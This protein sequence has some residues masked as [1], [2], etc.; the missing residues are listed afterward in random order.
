MTTPADRVVEALRASL[1]ENERLRHENHRL[2]ERAR[3]PIAI[4]AMSCRYPGGVGTPEELWELVAAGRDAIGEFPA[5]RGWDLD[6]LFDAD[7]DHPGTSYAREGGFLHDAP[8][9]DADFF[10]ISPREAIAMDPQQRLLLEAVWEAVERTGTDPLALRGS[11]T[12]VF[13]GSHGQ[14]YGALQA[15][16]ARGV[17]G[18]L[19]TGSGGA[20]LSGRVAYTL[21]LAGPAVT[22]DTACSSSLVALHLAC[23][24]LRDDD[25]DRALV[26]GVSVMSTPDGWIAF[27]RQRGLA[28]DGRCKAFAAAA[29][30]TG[31]AEGVGVLVL[32]RLS[33]ARRAGRPVLALVRGSAIN[34]DGASNG[35]T[36]PSGPA[37]ERVIRQALAAA[38]LTPADVDA[39]EAHGT[40]TTLGDPIEAHAVLAAYG[41]DRPAGRPLL[42]GSLKSNI[43]HAQAAAG[44]GGVI[45]MVQAMRH[46]E[47]PRTLHVDAPSPHV[48]WSAGAVE[49]LTEHRPWPETGRPR[50][51]GV[52]SFGISGTNAHAILEQA[53]A[54]PGATTVTTAAERPAYPLACPVSAKTPAALRAHAGRL[55]AHL[56]D[57][58]GLDPADVAHTLATARSAFRERAV[59]I[60]AD[61]AGLLAGLDAVATGEPAPGV[62][63][64]TAE[65]TRRPALL[66]SGQ[67]AQRAGMGRA[68]AA[69]FPEFAAVLARTCEPLDA[70]LAGGP[71]GT[72]AHRPL[73]AVL[74]AEPGSPD[75]GLLDRTVYTQAGLFALE[76]ALFRLVESWGVRPALVLGHSIGGLAAAHVAGVF[77]L[78][79]ACALVAAR[80]RLM[81]ALPE[82][83]AMLSV[84]AAEEEIAPLLAAHADDLSVAAVN[85]P[86][87]TVLSGTAAA[88]ERIAGVLAERGVRTRRLRVSHAFHSPL[89]E[90]MLAEF[91]AVAER[92]GYAEPRIP[93]VSDLTG[94]IADPAEITTAD[95]WVRHIRC[96]VRYSD[97]V[98]SA[99]ALGARTFLELGPDG[100]LSA[101]GRDCLPATATGAAPLF[102]PAL[103]RTRPEDH[104]LIEAMAALHTRGA[105]SL[106]PL[107]PGGGTRPVQLPTYPFQRQRYWPAGPAT[108]AD[109]PAPDAA[110]TAP[111]TATKDVPLARRLAAL[112]AGERDAALLRLVR[113]HAA[114]VLGHTHR[115]AVPAD[116][117]FQELGFDSLTAVEF[118]N[119]LDTATGLRLPATLV[120]DHP[121]PAALAETLRAE[122]LGGTAPAEAPATGPG[123]PAEPIAI[124]GMGCRL[125]GGVGGPD[126]LW[127]LLAAGG[128]AIT[129]FPTDRGWDLD[130]LYHPDPDHPGTSYT[131]SGGFVAGAADFD[132]AFFGI[133][134][135][136]ALAMDP[137]QRL[138]LEVS[139]EALERA[140]IPPAS[141]RGSR[142]GVYAGVVSADYAT[143]LRAVP[144]GLEG[145][146][147]NGS[148]ISVLSGRVAYT[149]GL[150]GPALTVD[151]ACSSSLVALHLACQA[152]RNGEC[153]MALTGGVTIMSTPDA[154]IQFSRQ[155]GLA[156]D[157]RCKAFAAAADGTGWGEGVGV[158]VVERLST[159]LAN[160]HPVLAVVRGT[161]VNQDG[162]SNGLTAPNGP[163]QQRVIRQALAAARLTPADVD[164]VEA[165]GTGTRLGDPIE[166][167]ALIA[168]YGQDRPA[169]RPLL[170]GSLK[171]NI[172]HTLGAAGVAGVIK[173][174]LA[175]RHGE[176]PR[177]LHV[178]A[179]SPHVDWSAGAVE[180]L[181][182]HRPWPETGRPHR[183]AVSSFGV[184]GT[185]AH[186]I[187]EQPPDPTDTAGPAP[188]A[189]A[190][191][192]PWILS[193]RTE[194][195]LRRQAAR[196]LDHVTGG[197]GLDPA[198]VGATLAS[199]R[200]VFR[201]GAV[202]VAADRA[203]FAEGL[204]ALAAGE[205]AAGVAEHRAGPEPGKTAFLFSGQGAQ[206]PRMGAGLRDHH[207]VFAEVFDDVAARLDAELAGHVDVPLRDVLAAAPGTTAAGLL[208]R[209]VY[210]QTALFAFETA[211]A[212]LL[213][214]WG[215]RP[216]LVLGHSIGAL[217]AA[218]VA[219][220]FSLEDACALVAARARLMQA[221]PE[222]GAMLSVRAAEE[223]IAPLLAAHADD[224]SVAAVNGP[225]STVLSGREPAVAELAAH[226]TDRGVRTR[227]LRVSHAFH[228]PLMEPMLAEFR[229]VAK[230]VHYSEPRIPVVSDLTGEAA[231]PAEIT[232]ADYWVRHVRSPVRFADAVRRLHT[233]GAGTFVEIGPA[234]VLTPMARDC[235]PDDADPAAFLPAQRADR[236]EPHALVTA[237]ATL[238]LRG[239]RPDWSRL[240]G[241]RRPRPAELPT[242]AFDHRRYWLED[243]A[244][245]STRHPATAPTPEPPAPAHPMTGPWLADLP[246]GQ[247]RTA[248]LDL[249]RAHAAAVLGYPEPEAVEDRRPF[250]EIGLDSLSAVE[251]RDRLAA[252]TGLR[253]G[254]SLLFDHATPADLADHVTA[255]L[256]EEPTGTAAGTGTAPLGPL[257]T[258]YL[259]ACER[260]RI[261]EATHLLEAASRIR[262][263]FHRTRLPDPPDPVRLAR[264]GTGP[265]LVC[266][267]SFSPVAGPQ[268]YARFAAHF[269]GDRDVLA[270]REPGFADGEPL[271]ADLDALARLQAEA[272]R[273]HL[274][275]A[276]FVLV[277]RS[278]SGW[279]AHAVTGELAETG[280]APAALVLLD[281]SSPEHMERTGLGD[282][283]GGA[284][285]DRESDADLL[286]DVKLSA[287]G[288]YSRIF[289]GWRPRPVTTPTLLVRAGE[290]FAGIDPDGEWR[291]FWE[292]PHTAVDVPGDHFSILEDHSATTA[293]AVAAWLTTGTDTDHPTPSP[294]GPADNMRSTP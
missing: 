229:T 113:A 211:L 101:M 126:D 294:P 47:L 208:D 29:D 19:A 20:V 121:T 88:V 195:A 46:G 248:V 273:R 240:F 206:R 120:F 210:T 111:E 275:T 14:D 94:E 13:T 36:A 165:H 164:A 33:A 197:P 235:L 74:A 247:R 18:Y 82:G 6:R 139:W 263:A 230:Q 64:G 257:A 162:A 286:S 63:T 282:A 30:G 228:S 79:D 151:T 153:D 255:R 10:G 37:Q 173:T 244:P 186:V 227:R 50:R 215:V 41:R 104:T 140:G 175:M 147:G 154:F 51:A 185:N 179:P 116:R 189:P 260:G 148:A 166:A 103:R 149:L 204:R 221:L 48:D 146:L 163:S 233:A 110:D 12:G 134:P 270:L 234:A 15:K 71:P 119:R 232:T 269:R 238:H 268:E 49:L 25:C 76:T 68:A 78:E 114:A 237:V 224:L 16:L 97:A 24:A 196:L 117:P 170:L 7:P 40:G 85:G 184:S 53:P 156:A 67:G 150:E 17:D 56:R 143:R 98:R 198:D 158:L 135:R 241:A 129:D 182:E 285:V 174:V 220:V 157:G 293:Q 187:L 253:L 65:G 43:G 177:T 52:S 191:V 77:S 4:T 61:R 66:F 160:G 161:A 145:Y 11:R 159:A 27:S 194:T 35:L 201:H 176:L 144:E 59:V 280:P 115:D 75:A 2:G 290:P 218:H 251:L 281:S 73:A 112:P 127:R 279:L 261:A 245:T 291:S 243:A 28:A 44:V 242:Y 141:L 34:Q 272:V 254:A 213:A 42:L 192:L 217:A 265:A 90:P 219:G 125:P 23:Q 266:L 109:T 199:G 169:G 155:R 171:S 107:I 258:L 167:Q 128:D 72:A 203:A 31:F 216:A 236:A 100:V 62:L 209:T 250:L 102:V 223:E 1:K 95:Y 9:F 5:D 32:E 105:A 277:G 123:D 87:A 188:S 284:M 60:A 118:R 69:A 225:R 86:Q 142:T 259:Q 99:H 274:G 246:A 132:P 278:A 288:C 136:E 283:M 256:A 137:Q 3:E 183:A 226:L 207:P 271:P 231:D 58:P 26:A 81:Q 80:G 45:K 239:V 133:S 93:V 70:H 91:R 152:L 267:P 287:M 178:D 57:R 214:D 264:G 39:V 131:R 83:G 202:V 89:M 180:L 200:E 38:R 289:A 190:T 168:A 212:R 22:V 130:A 54:E 21:G 124:V 193:A 92:V 96:P 292:P 249:V 108:A 138:M 262:P 172:G 84:R 122:L 181:T 55:A 205:P 8:D 222:G 276:P 252:A 106:A